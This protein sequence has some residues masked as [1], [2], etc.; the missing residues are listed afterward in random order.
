MASNNDSPVLDGIWFRPYLL[1]AGTGAVGATTDSTSVGNSLPA[2]AKV[3]YCGAV[4]TNSSD[5]VVLPSLADVPNG[6]EIII[7]AQATSNF[8][9]RTPATSNEKINNIDSDGSN[10]YLVSDTDIVR[11]IKVNNTAGWIGQSFTNLG[12]VRT[13]VIPS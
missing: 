13:A 2:T 10:T 5:F 9:L 3:G 12:A 11:V 6:H 7:I 4:T 1:K 8:G